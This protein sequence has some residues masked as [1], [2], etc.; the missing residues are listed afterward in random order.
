MARAQA[1]LKGLAM[2]A[3]TAMSVVKGLAL[4][5]LG[6]GS[7]FAG[8]AIGGLFK[9]IFGEAVQQAEE[10]EQR[11]KKL[12]GA[13]MANAKMRKLG[14]DIGVQQTKLLQDHNEQL[15]KQQVFSGD[16]LD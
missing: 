8:F 5:F 9:K 13:L 3:K 6:L 7:I 14:M 2:A 1:R 12:T 15:S 16:I 10:A 11:T 4:G